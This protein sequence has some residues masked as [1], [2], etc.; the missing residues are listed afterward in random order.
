M[1]SRKL[2]LMSML[3]AL[4]LIIFTVEAQLPPLAPIPGIKLGL[5]NIITLVS[6][7]LLGRRD[8]FI[9]LVSRI[10]LGSIFAGNF[11][12]FLYSIAGGLVCFLCMCAAMTVIKEKR[13]WLISIFGALGHNF[14]QIFAACLILKTPQ[15][16][17]YLPALIISAIITGA[18]TGTVAQLTL[19][20]LKK[21]K[22]G[23]KNA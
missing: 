18:F 15:I 8:S 19:R 17:W 14:G 9:I 5:A 2:A 22:Q 4:A 10:G 21:T 23:D 1:T 13:V 16:L 12:G 11:S 7:Y 6:L 20:R 3:L